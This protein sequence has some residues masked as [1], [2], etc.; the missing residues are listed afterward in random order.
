MA[1]KGKG[2]GGYP[3]QATFMQAFGGL[4]D[5]VTAARAG[6]KAPKASRNMSFGSAASEAL[7]LRGGK[8]QV[9]A[10][11]TKPQSFKKPSGP[12]STGSVAGATTSPTGPKTGPDALKAMKE[13]F[14]GL[15]P[16]PLAPKPGPYKA[17]NKDK[18]SRMFGFA[19]AVARK[20]KR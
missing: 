18:R 15:G 7:G 11:I 6:K 12:K 8:G 10:A 4:L 19:Q 2:G 17:A 16:N 13:R 5:G 20:K 3:K 1:R 14:T 9:R